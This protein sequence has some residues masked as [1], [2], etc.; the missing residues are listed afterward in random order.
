MQAF[1]YRNNSEVISKNNYIKLQLKGE[2][3]NTFA[4]GSSVKIYCDS[5]IIAHDLMPSRGFQSSMDYVITLGL[6]KYKQIDSI[7]VIWPN[8]TTQKLSKVTSNQLLV[9]KQSE[10][11]SIYKPIVAKKASP[12]F[13]EVEN[14]LSK[15]QEN[16][17]SDFD[18]EGLIPK[19]LSQEGPALAIGDINNDGNEDV[20]I[21]GAK[22]QA[23]RIYKN[24]GKGNLVP[25]SSNIFQKDMNFEDTAA[26]FFD[27]DND[28]DLDLMVGSGG[29]EV[30]E[31]R[32]Y[33]AR[34]YMNDGEGNFIRSKSKIPSVHTN[35]AVVSPYDFDNDGDIDVFV[36]SRSVVGTYGIDPPHL[37]LENLGNGD[38]LNATERVTYDLKNAGM[39]TDA[40]WEDTDGDSRK[41]LI[42]VS[43]WGSPTIYKNN[44]RQLVRQKSSLD[45][46]NGWWNTI[47]T[48]DLDNDGDMDLI[49]GNQG[50]NT[51][52]K[53][54]VDQPMKMWINDY[55][56]NG[57]I[58]QIFTRSYD[59][60]DYPLH[61]KKELTAQIVS[62]KK[63]NLKASVYAKKTIGELFRKDVFENSIM[64]QA[65]IAESIIAINEGNGEYSI[66]AL[67]S[68]VQLSCVCGISCM[69]INGDGFMDIIMG[70]NNFEFK[71]QYSRL[72]A[73]DGSVLLNNKDLTFEWQDYNKSG[74]VVKN[75]VKHIAQFKDKNGDKYIIAVVNDDEPKI[76]EVDD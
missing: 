53:A 43:E 20:F 8:S 1:V 32:N 58:E 4:I 64:K 74:F 23:G 19:M 27:A 60:K 33:G 59:Y 36:G 25:K 30:G 70:G 44:G 9:L 18:H 11:N 15:H 40:L 14:T 6:G 22:N 10:A 29:N 47:E 69:D 71:P 46:L 7:R 3:D 37:F 35:I 38:F 61:M 73:N 67:P 51:A 31:E 42:T 24:L 50:S 21:G 34:L 63:Q 49:I 39:I 56:N 26:S 76:F 68:R 41:D 52:Y 2:N 45:S 28:G 16:S 13:K 12:L 65:T 5:T 55:D 75:E 72:D 17:Y 66:K 54:S 48:A 57:T 62:L